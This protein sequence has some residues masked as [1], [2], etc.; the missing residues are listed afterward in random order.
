MAT[1]QFMCQKIISRQIGISEDKRL[2]HS[3]ILFFLTFLFFMASILPCAGESTQNFAKTGNASLGYH[4]SPPVQN[5]AG[6]SSRDRSLPA[7]EAGPSLPGTVPEAEGLLPEKSSRSGKVSES[8]I[9]L[10]LGFGLIT[11]AGFGRRK[12]PS[13]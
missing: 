3:K 4:S 9:L 2:M 6:A 7:N 11:I 8:A 5:T 13:R 10:F 1:L 12:S